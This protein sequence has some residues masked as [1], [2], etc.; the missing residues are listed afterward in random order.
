MTTRTETVAGETGF[1]LSRRRL[2]AGLAAGAG[3]SV[4][5]RWTAHASAAGSTGGHTLVV[6]FLRGGPDGCSILVP[7][8]D[9]TYHDRRPGIALDEPDVIPFDTTFGLH[10]AMAPLTPLLDAG[11]IAVVPACGSTLGTRSHFDQQAHIER[12]GTTATDARGAGWLGRV[13]DASAPNG[14]DS[15]FRAIAMGGHVPPSLAGS[16][17]VVTVDAL[18]EVGPPAFPGMAPDDVDT[19]LRRL[20]Q[21]TGPAMVLTAGVGA[22][23]AI[24]VLLDAAARTGGSAATP[25]DDP[26]G[27]YGSEPV[28]QT[29]RDLARLIRADI[30]VDVATV[31]V[32]GWDTHDDMGDVDGGRMAAL[33]ET[34]A[35]A[36]AAFADEAGDAIERT[37][38]LAMGEFGRRV[39]E[40]GSGGTDHGRGGVLLAMG[41]HVKGG[42][43]GEWPG[44]SP[45]V[46]DQGDIPVATDW[47]KVAAE[48][49]EGPHGIDDVGAILPDVGGARLG[50]VHA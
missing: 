21:T 41:G 39:V 48:V 14:D 50:I 9:A 38:V 35:G 5:P 27:L 23:D 20:H 13:L 19:A 36:L 42:R 16:D 28:K 44:L 18:D 29:F 6:V 37:T 32:G 46:L 47:R 22:L 34:L 49:L 24:P 40:N 33:V 4:A 31:D 12:G 43:H 26:T 1:H 15:G 25:G 8:G 30:G 11:R 2:L 7:A 3:A 45:D 17:A 10:T